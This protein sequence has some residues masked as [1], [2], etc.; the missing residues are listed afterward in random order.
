MTRPLGKNVTALIPK[1]QRVHAAR[2]ATYINAARLQ[3][4]EHGYEWDAPY[5]E[6][7]GYFVKLAHAPRGS[8]PSNFNPAWHLDS[9][10]I[11]FAKAYVTEQHLKNP[12][13]SR[14]GHIKRLQTLRFLEANLIELRGTGDPTQMDGAVLDAAASQARNTLQGSGAYR[15]GKE[16]RQ[17]AS[18]LVRHGVLPT[19]CGEWVNPNKQPSNATIAVTAEAQRQREKRLPDHEALYAL[20]DIFSRDLDPT[21]P[22]NCSDIYITSVAALL[23]CAPARGQEI[24]RLPHNLEFRATDK[25]GDEQLGLRLEASKGFGSYIK[26]VWSEMVPVA[27]KAIERIKAITNEARNLA[28]HFEDP[29]SCKHFYR[30]AGCPQ[31]HDHEPLTAEQA[32]LAL[33]LNTNNP[34]SILN[35][36][37]LSAAPGVHTLQSLWDGFVLPRHHKEHPHFPYISATDIALGK[38]GGL[39]YSEAL[40]CMRRFELS[41]S[42]NASPIQLWMPD[43]NVFSHSVRG[44]DSQQSIFH[45]YSY[46][47][48]DGEPLSLTSHQIRHLINT[49][50]QRSGLADEQIAHWSGRKR[51]DQNTVYDHRTIDERTEQ[52]REVVE[53]VQSRLALVQETSNEASD[54]RHGQWLIKVVRKP[55]SLVDVEDIQPHLSGLKTLYGECHHD[56]TL[57]P[58]EGFV[59]CLDCREHAC[60]KGS[61]TDSKTKLERLENLRQSV[62]RE[63]AKAQ[64]ASADDVDAQ[65]WLK[66]Q[67]RYAAKV[68]ELIA[69]LRSDS[70]P[71]GSVI[72]SADGQHPTHMHRA[73]RG[74]AVKAIANGTESKQ[75]MTELLLAI[76]TGIA[77]SSNNTSILLAANERH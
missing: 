64:A 75:A 59:K 29:E 33:G 5:W 52:T 71:D 76:E 70:V 39:K 25:F 66:V 61:D 58:C 9:T 44:S 69:I 32:C 72:R 16:L 28:R 3:A 20:A 15:I 67:E 12:A 26:W 54:V 14:S 53:E 46:T 6:G 30:H 73:L 38:K 49:E 77:G 4:L 35:K 11:D 47:K 21:D 27:E 41:A 74:L 48:P 36:N 34:A 63:V 43:L 2:L 60:I 45:R 57:A 23:M 40:F 13:E 68:D 62:L 31:V 10:F 50:A 55:R 65:D 17:L 37:G 19:I 24:H 1:D 18:V 56:W 22:R 51:I 42:R 8:L 7:V